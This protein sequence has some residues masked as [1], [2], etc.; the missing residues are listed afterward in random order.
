MFDLL[1]KTEPGV[2]RSKETW[3]GKIA[4]IFNRD[5]FGDDVWEEL[6][7]L[8]VSADVGVE[9]TNKLLSKVR[10]RVKTDKLPEVSQIREALKEEMV[11][12]L[13]IPQSANS[14]PEQSRE[15]PHIILVV[16]VNGSGKTTSIAKLGYGFTSKGKRVILAAAD[17]FRAAAIEQLKHWGGNV[18]A[19]VIAHQPGG[20]PGAV[21]YDA[22]QAGC[23]RHA[24]VVII[25]TAG[26]LHT[27]FNL[28][29]ELKKIRRVV[30]KQDASAP[31]QVLLVM[32]ATTGQNGLAQAKYFTEAVGVTGIFLAKLDGTARGGIVFAICD[33]LNIPIS[34]IGTGE[35]LQDMTPFDAEVFVNA[36]FS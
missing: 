5:T 31:H 28:M 27:K 24:Q 9:T 26:R 23:N 17:T 8:L 16:G 36:I 4:N 21:A 35:K 6:E 29:E 15:F 10:Q 18:D 11:N 22:V 13:N 30:A 1:K 32:D 3:F 33:Q 14:T 25:D 7:E 20:D 19:E 2:K 12:L 34:Y